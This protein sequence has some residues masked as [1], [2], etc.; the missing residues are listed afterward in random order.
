[1]AHKLQLLLKY[2]V[3][4]DVLMIEAIYQYNNH[5]GL[6]VL[7]R[8]FHLKLLR[9]LVIKKVIFNL[10]FSFYLIYYKIIKLINK[11]VF[12]GFSIR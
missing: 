1:M 9:L 5:I 12:G 6:K 3:H 2:L 11:F 7:K 10:F 4:L 8:K